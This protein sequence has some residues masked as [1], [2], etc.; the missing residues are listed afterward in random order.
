MAV[1]VDP[2]GKTV[3][4]GII[5]VI[6]RAVVKDPVGGAGRAHV[7]AA[8][9]VAVVVVRLAGVGGGVVG[10]IGIVRAGQLAGGIVNIVG[11]APGI[12][13]GGVGAGKLL[14]D[15]AVGVVAPL[16]GGQRVGGL[17]NVG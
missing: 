16:I 3:P 14:L 8:G 2:L 12:P 10:E 7:V 5:L 13:A 11:L 17:R 6:V 15:A 1:V 9:A 4:V